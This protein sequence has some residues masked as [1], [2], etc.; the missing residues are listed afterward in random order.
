[1]ASGRLLTH[2]NYVRG[3]CLAPRRRLLFSSFSSSS[4]SS[5]GFRG[6]IVSLVRARCALT[7]CSNEG[8][9]L[10]QPRPRST[11]RRLCRNA[12]K[13]QFDVV[14]AW[15]VDRLGVF[16]VALDVQMCRLFDLNGYRKTKSVQR[17]ARIKP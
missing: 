11:L 4:S 5:L 10:L 3:P 1:V 2:Q 14:M 9:Y 17:P 16:L 7:H 13:R 8:R 12:A 6:G 15:S